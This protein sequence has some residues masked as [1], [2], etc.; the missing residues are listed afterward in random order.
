MSGVVYDV[1]KNNV[2]GCFCYYYG[3][4]IV[5]EKLFFVWFL[6]SGF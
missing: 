5:D 1:V 2:C 3:C 4:D 6:F